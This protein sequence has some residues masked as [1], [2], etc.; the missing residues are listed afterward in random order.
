VRIAPKRLGEIDVLS[1]SGEFDAS[2]APVAEIDDLIASG[3]R[4]LVCSFGELRFITSPVIGYL[5][6]SAK[7]LKGLGGEIV[8]AEPS[9]FML[10]TIRTLGLDQIFEV[11]PTEGEAVAHLAKARAPGERAA[12]A[13]ALAD[14]PDAEASGRILSLHE[15]G[16][17]LKYPEDPDRVRIDPEELRGGR[18][19]RLRFREPRL[20]RLVEAEAEVAAAVGGRYRLR[21]T[22]IDARDR[23]ALARLAGGG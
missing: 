3:R 2:K 4:R 9:R 23:D 6:K 13:F 10:A 17:T 18:R 8:L 1:F 16:I 14:A 22:R 12:V 11:F 20:D 5:V 15:D 19:L 21:Y 7:R